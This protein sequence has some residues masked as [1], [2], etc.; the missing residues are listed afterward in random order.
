MCF[1]SHCAGFSLWGLVS[2]DW[3]AALHTTVS[4]HGE[5]LETPVASNTCLLLSSGFLQLALQYSSFVW[6]KL[7]LINL[8]LT[9]ISCALSHSQIFWQFNNLYLLFTKY[10]LFWCLLQDIALF[11]TFHLRKDLSSSPYFMRTVNNLE[12]PLYV[13]FPFT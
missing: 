2:S 8:Y 4:L 1:Y 5:D 3:N 13:G 7:S 6:Q 12:Q 10:C 9:K 11:H